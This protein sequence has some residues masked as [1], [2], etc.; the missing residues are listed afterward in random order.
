[1]PPTDGGNKEQA[2]K[3]PAFSESIA[4]DG[5][6][7]NHGAPRGT[8]A[9]RGRRGGNPKPRAQHGGLQ[10][11]PDSC[12][13][14]SEPGAGQGALRDAALAAGLDEAEVSGTI[15]SGLD[16]APS[17]RAGQSGS[18]RP[19]KGRR[20]S[21]SPTAGCSMRSSLTP[22]PE[23]PASDFGSAAGPWIA[24]AARCATAPPDYVAMALLSVAGSLVGNACWVHPWV[25]WSEP[26][27]HL[28]H[29]G[30]RPELRQ[31]PGAQEGDRA[32]GRAG[33]PGAGGGGACPHR[34][35]TVDHEAVDT[36]LLT[37]AA[38]HH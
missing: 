13:R 28:G 35:G 18:I 2:Y 34:L 26:S 19:A 7:G 14:A 23:F 12:C 8:R 33:A 37:G 10:P 29:A 22:A 36:G 20:N 27:R 32:A 15:R 24:D 5:F 1:M 31:E 25:G 3:L 30:R 11:R 6:L 17:N 38:R 16:A 4:R 21:P 9:R